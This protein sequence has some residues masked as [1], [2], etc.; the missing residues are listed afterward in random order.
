MDEA[1]DEE[2]S[3]FVERRK[4]EGGA[5]T[6]FRATLRVM[7][8]PGWRLLGARA[9]RPQRAEGP[10]SDDRNDMPEPPTPP[11]KGKAWYSRGSSPPSR[12]ARHRPAHPLLLGRRTPRPCRDRLENRAEALRPRRRQRSPHQPRNLRKRIE[13]DRRPGT[14]RVLVAR[15][16]RR[17]GRAVADRAR[18]ESVIGASQCRGSSAEL[19]GR[20]G[21]PGG[22]SG[23]GVLSK[24]GPGVHRGVVLRAVA[25]SRH[26]LGRPAMCL[27]PGP[28]GGR[29][30]FHAQRKRGWHKGHPPKA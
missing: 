15:R 4:R 28:R 22:S 6:D 9:S 18:P 16:P 2:L 24:P 26:F 29:R 21:E 1:I 20:R 13:R 14:R 3:A 11:H 27:D 17:R 8:S 23:P 7:A 12:P 30:V 5:P 25:G 10:Q 19:L